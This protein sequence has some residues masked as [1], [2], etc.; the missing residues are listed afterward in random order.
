MRDLSYEYHAR[1]SRNHLSPHPPSSIPYQ[2]LSLTTTDT[3]NYAAI[4]QRPHRRRHRSRRRPRESVSNTPVTSE[5]R[6]V[7]VEAAGRYSLLFASRGAN[8]VVNDFNQA[9]AQKVV[10]EITQGTSHADGRWC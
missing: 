6:K 1:Q 3:P 9:A 4:V 5:F 10:D 8:V 2:R 7:D